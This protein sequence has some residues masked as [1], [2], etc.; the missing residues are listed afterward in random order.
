MMNATSAT[1]AANK[2]TQ[3]NVYEPVNIR[4]YYGDYDDGDKGGVWNDGNF[5]SIVA[6]N[7]VNAIDY[8][9]IGGSVT[10][11]NNATPVYY[12]RDGT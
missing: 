8:T 9:D 5:A 10:L 12:K 11:N 1:I 2:I 6:Y 3:S 7:A 4:I